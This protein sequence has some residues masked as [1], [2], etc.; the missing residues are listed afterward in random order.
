MTDPIPGYFLRWQKIREKN[1]KPDDKWEPV[2]RP[3]PGDPNYRFYIEMICLC[4]QPKYEYQANYNTYSAPVGVDLNPAKCAICHKLDVLP[5]K[6]CKNCDSAFYDLFRHSWQ[7]KLNHYCWWCVED[8]EL[9]PTIFAEENDWYLNRRA[10]GEPGW[11]DHPPP[12]F[13]LAPKEVPKTTA[14]LLDELDIL[15]AELGI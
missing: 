15:A 11:D 10:K 8:H 6:K 12:A 5:F 3:F 1:K 4:E 13:L 2:P 14:D 7:A 9:Y